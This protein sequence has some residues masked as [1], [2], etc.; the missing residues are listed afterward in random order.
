MKILAEKIWEDGQYTIDIEIEN[1]I[2]YLSEVKRYIQKKYNVMYHLI[3]VNYFDIIN[4]KVYLY[5]DN[6]I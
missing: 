3:K 5:F 2:F 1:N 4:N 6:F